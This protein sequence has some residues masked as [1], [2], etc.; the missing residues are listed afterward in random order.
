MQFC[1][2]RHSNFR[3]GNDYFPQKEKVIG[4]RLLKLNSKIPSD[5]SVRRDF[6]ERK[7]GSPNKETA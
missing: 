6:F 5:K 2:N 4:K 3:R 1:K 7:S